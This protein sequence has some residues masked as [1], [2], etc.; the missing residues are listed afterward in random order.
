MIKDID[1]EFFLYGYFYD[2]IKKKR[3]YEAQTPHRGFIV[4]VPTQMSCVE[5]TISMSL[6]LTESYQHFFLNNKNEKE[7]SDNIQLLID[8]FVC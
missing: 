1:K 7:Q 3:K 6:I 5:R 2:E 4:V 8:F